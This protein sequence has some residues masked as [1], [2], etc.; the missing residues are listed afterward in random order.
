VSRVTDRYLAFIPVRGGS[1]S[2]PLK[3][4]KLI[5]GKPLVHWAI[6]AAHECEDISRIVVSTDSDEIERVA[7][8]YGSKKLSVHRRS[9]ET[10]TDDASTESAM[11]EFAKSDDDFDAMVLIQATSPL[12]TAQDLTRGIAEY[13]SGGHDAVLSVVRQRRFVWR[14]G[15]ESA[16]SLNYEVCSR[17]RRQDYDGLLVENGAFYITPRSALLETGCRISGSIGLVEMDEASYFE[18]DEPSDWTIVEGLLLARESRCNTTEA[19]GADLSKIR[20]VLTDCDGVLTDG[21]MY[22]SEAGDELKRFQTR[23]GVGFAALRRAGLV[24]GIITGESVA[25]VGRRAAKLD[26]DEVHVGITDKMAVIDDICEQYSL[27]YDEI[28]YIGD[29]IADVPVIS[30]VGFGCSVADGMQGVKAAADYVTDARGGE[31]ALREVAELILAAR[32]SC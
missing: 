32:A 21:G 30:A 11:L 12:L 29:D 28:A 31:G 4:T 27:T 20:A 1:K 18:I 3:N 6:D 13:E 26:L 8:A 22:Y 24:V 10:A 9:A 16:E 5:A 14:E 15:E 25:L 7:L 2:I 17:P 19:M 23:D